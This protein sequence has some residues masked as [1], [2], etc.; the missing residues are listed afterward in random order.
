MGRGGVDRASS[1]DALGLWF[2]PN[3]IS[4]KYLFLLT[5]MPRGFLEPLTSN[6]IEDRGS[7]LLD[8]RSIDLRV[9]KKKKVTFVVKTF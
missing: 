6:I 4:K 5:W 3:S 1:S 9:N 8:R 2:E 7:M